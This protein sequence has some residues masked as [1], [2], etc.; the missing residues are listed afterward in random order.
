MRNRKLFLYLVFIV[1]V[2]TRGVS[3]LTIDA[4]G[5]VR[6]LKHE[7]TSGRGG[8]VG[9]RRLSLRLS[10]NVPSAVRD[11]AGTS[12]VEFILTNT[13]TSPITLPTSPNPGDFE[14]PDPATPYSV[15][16]LGLNISRKGKPGSFLKGGA[17][18]FGNESISES[19]AR[20][21]PGNFMHIL[22]RVALPEREG[23]GAEEF[24]ADASLTN[25]TIKTESGKLV[26][27]SQEIGYAQSEEYSFNSL[28]QA[29]P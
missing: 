10:I 11:A 5:P 22:A 29:R 1:T 8:V 17:I 15:M 23:Q 7:P 21:A 6:Q 20:L 18:L 27:D 13:G 25:Q 16:V 19:V 4:T 26:S 28:L 3:Q 12:L 2:T 14:P 24:V 9:P